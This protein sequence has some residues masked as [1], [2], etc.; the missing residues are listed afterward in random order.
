MQKRN[1]IISIH[2]RQCLDGQEDTVVQEAEG[3]LARAGA[4]WTLAYREGENSGLGDTKTILRLEPERVTLTRLGELNSR[5]VFQVGV[6][7]TSPYETPYGAIPLTVRTHR[8]ETAL[9]EEGGTIE[10]DYQ[11]ELGGGAAGVNRLRLQV[12]KKENIL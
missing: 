11:I 3:L 1:V 12:R 10:I 6:P 5:M 2:S 7:H 4:G 8:L 9:E